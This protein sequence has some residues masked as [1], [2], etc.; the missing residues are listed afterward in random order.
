MKI[1]RKQNS[2][3]GSYRVKKRKL[4][5]IPTAVCAVLVLA[6]V[7]VVYQELHREQWTMGEPNAQTGDTSADAGDGAEID[8]SDA[9][10]TSKYEEDGSGGNTVTMNGKI[11]RYNSSLEN[12]L[13][14]GIDSREQIDTGEAPGNVGQ[15]DALFLVSWDR[16]GNTLTVISIPRDTMTQIELFNP[17]GQSLGMSRSHINLAYAYGDGAHG[18]C[19]L[20]VKAV[21]NLFYG[22]EIQGYCSISLD[23]IPVLVEVVPGVQVTVPNDSLEERD[24]MFAE[25]AT[26]DLTPDNA[27]TFVRYRDI[28]VSQSALMRVERQKVFMEAYGTRLK[29]LCAKDPGVAVDLYVGLEPY[30]VTNLDM[31]EATELAAE[32]AGAEIRQWTVPGEGQEGL[33]F[34]EYIVDDDALYTQIIETFYTEVGKS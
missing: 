16:E 13:F 22:L 29:E 32:L 17:Q 33:D 14:L 20:S 21:S 6:G 1:G 12:Y 28:H 9:Y 30:M 23:G 18:S 25:G 34:D 7:S 3:P 24:P 8:F 19:R 27:E 31:G 15:S 26:V 2:I 4:W 11:Y 10:D 5:L